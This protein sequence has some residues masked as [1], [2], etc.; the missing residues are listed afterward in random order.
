MPQDQFSF[1][2]R[3]RF[4]LFIFILFSLQGIAQTTEITNSDTR[5]QKLSRDI[6][7]ELIE[8]NTTSASIN[9]GDEELN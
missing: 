3:F 8:I 7:R 2:I 5:Y 1:S 4:L 6:F 9:Q